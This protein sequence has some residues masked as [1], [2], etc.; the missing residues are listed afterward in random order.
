M[1]INALL[2]TIILVTFIVTI[3]AAV[4][5]LPAVNGLLPR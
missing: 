2:S 4:I 3:L 1:S 5:L